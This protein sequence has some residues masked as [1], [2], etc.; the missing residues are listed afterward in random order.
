MES[1]DNYIEQ[2]RVKYLKK[3]YEENKEKNF[4]Q[5][6]WESGIPKDKLRT[7]F[8]RYKI[9]KRVFARI[10]TSIKWEKEYGD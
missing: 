6:M 7:W 10:G 8:Q 2:C 3:L 4:E 5:L 1:Y 9:T